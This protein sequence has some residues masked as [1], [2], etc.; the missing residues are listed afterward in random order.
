MADFWNGAG[1]FAHHLNYH[2]RVWIMPVAL[3]VGI[4]GQVIV[5]K[6]CLTN[7]AWKST[8]KVY[9]FLMSI[10]DL[11]I[12]LS[13]GLLSYIET[14]LRGIIDISPMYTDLSCKLLIYSF[15][16]L[17]TVSFWNLSA[18]AVERLLAIWFP[19]IRIQYI[20]MKNARIIC[21]IICAVA[22]LGYTPIFWT[23]TF[24]Y[25]GYCDFH[26]YHE[27]VVLQIWYWTMSV[28]ITVLFGPIIVLIANI[29]LLIKLHAYFEAKKALF[30]KSL[31][32]KSKKE[33][34]NTEVE[35]AKTVV[36]LSIS[37]GIILLPMASWIVAAI[38]DC[39]LWELPAFNS[40]LEHCKIFRKTLSVWSILP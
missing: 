39:M 25:V 40:A 3:I 26:L 1:F 5:I 27:N 6:C 28:G 17:V 35:S 2:F 23:N 30:I 10:T 4:F 29:I 14:S 37:T 38:A 21:V 36:I 9:Y 33:M 24:V 20:S 31:Y 22:L 19:F 11:L 16:V 8:G 7:P 18:Y 13:L 15:H 12:L 32:G 34:P